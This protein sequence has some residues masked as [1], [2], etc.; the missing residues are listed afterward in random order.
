MKWEQE[1]QDFLDSPKSLSEG[2]Y[3]DWRRESLVTRGLAL[4]SSLIKKAH[5]PEAP[6]AEVIELDD[7]MRLKLEERL[8]RKGRRQR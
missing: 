3:Q 8:W 2:F 7:E 5:Q 6:L 4:I 1:D